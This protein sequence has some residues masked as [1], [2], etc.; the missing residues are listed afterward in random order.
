[1]ADLGFEFD[2]STVEPSTGGGNSYPL[3]PADTYMAEIVD[4]DLVAFKSGNGQYVWLEFSVV[5]GE[6]AGSKF[7][8]R[9]NIVNPNKPD[10]QKYALADL[11]AICR[12]VG[13]GPIKD[14]D[15][16]HF[17]PMLVKLKVQ[18]SRDKGDGSGEQWPAN[19]QLG[20]YKPIV[21]G[22]PPRTAATQT[23]QRPATAPAGAVRPSTPAA[24]KPAVGGATTPP[25][26]RS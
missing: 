20:G 1:M 24:A 3:L 14:T 2:S 25:W 18:P 7:D 22:D 5:E 15:P 19:N 23:T 8:A 10:N 11:S 13:S 4:S 17:K 12:A 6:Y 16:L 9:L 26:R 21:A